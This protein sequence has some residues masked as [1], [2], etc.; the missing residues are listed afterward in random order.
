MIDRAGARPGD[1]EAYVTLTARYGPSRR[2]SDGEQEPTAAYLTGKLKLDGEMGHRVRL[3][4]ILVLRWNP[5]PISQRS[6]RRRAGGPPI[7]S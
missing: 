1:E 5:P 3:A 4:A 6:R 7:G 2:S